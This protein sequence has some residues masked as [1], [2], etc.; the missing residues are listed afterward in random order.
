[1]RAC[2][3]SGAVS[4]DLGLV[5]HARFEAGGGGVA[6][7][8]V[9]RLRSGLGG[10]GTAGVESHGV[11]APD[12]NPGG[13]HGSSGSQLGAAVTPCSKGEEHSA[14]S[15]LGTAVNPSLPDSPQ[16]AA[17]EAGDENLKTATVA[18][19]N[20][21]NDEYEEGMDEAE[22]REASDSSLFSNIPDSQ[23]AKKKLYSANEIAEFL[24]VTKAHRGRCCPWSG[25]C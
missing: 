10:H 16:S 24:D 14:E 22:E 17:V 25:Y 8:S 20:N 19:E 18:V 12:S 13:S 6:L 21:S 1:M 23:T 11:G 5:Q 2:W 4:S 15:L 9:R 7:G 3:S